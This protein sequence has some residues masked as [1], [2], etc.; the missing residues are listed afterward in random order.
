MNNKVCVWRN[1][2]H[3]ERQLMMCQG[4]CPVLPA[5][6]GGWSGFQ[7]GKAWLDLQLFSSPALDLHFILFSWNR[8]L[9][10]QP[11]NHYTYKAGLELKIHLSQTPKCYY[12]R[13][14]PS[15]LVAGRKMDW[16]IVS[17]SK[18]QGGPHL[19]HQQHARGRRKMRN[20]T[21]ECVRQMDH[22]G[23]SEQVSGWLPGL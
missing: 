15:I 2:I 23:S 20:V 18:I 6:N 12:C 19:N 9:S 21:T 3:V 5:G 22:R 11:A 10:D 14:G 1:R 7:S 17:Y 16:S 13:H 8:V 4:A